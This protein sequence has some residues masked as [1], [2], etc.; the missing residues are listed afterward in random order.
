MKSK[1]QLIQHLC[2]TTY[3][4]THQIVAYIKE[5]FAIHA[6]IASYTGTI[7]TTGWIRKGVDKS[8][9]TKG[10][11][12]RLNII[13]AIRLDDLSETVVDQTMTVDSESIIEFLNKTWGF[14][15]SNR[16]IHLVLDGAGYHHSL[17]VV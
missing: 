3:L 8:I 15:R 12:A 1:L 17:Q 5:T 11:H 2:E 14:Y 10:S 6:W 7:V 13:G 16:T 4:Q 9:E